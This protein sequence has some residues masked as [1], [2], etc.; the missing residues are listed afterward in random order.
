VQKHYSIEIALDMIIVVLTVDAVFVVPV[1]PQIVAA[2][3]NIVVLL[4]EV[5]IGVPLSHA[6]VENVLDVSNNDPSSFIV[7]LI[8]LFKAIGRS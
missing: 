8:V 3:V 7:K 6:V 1:I 4:K 5:I 2:W